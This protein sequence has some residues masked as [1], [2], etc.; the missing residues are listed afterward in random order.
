MSKFLVAHLL[1]ARL[2]CRRHLPAARP[3][4]ACGLARP[5]LARKRDQRVPAHAAAREHGVFEGACARLAAES[6]GVV[7]ESQKTLIFLRETRAM[8]KREWMPGRPPWE[9]GSGN[10]SRIRLCATRFVV[11]LPSFLPRTVFPLP[12][13]TSSHTARKISR[14]TDTPL[15]H[16]AQSQAARSQGGPRSSWAG[17]SRFVFTCLT[18]VF[19]PLWILPTSFSALAAGAFCMQDAWGVERRSPS[20]SLR[21]RCPR[22]AQRS[23][24]LG[25]TVSSASAQIEAMDAVAARLLAAVHAFANLPT[26]DLAPETHV[27]FIS[28]DIRAPLLVGAPLISCAPMRQTGTS[29]TPASWSTS[30]ART[31]AGFV[32][33]RSVC[34]RSRCYALVELATDMAESGF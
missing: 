12:A 21:W 34:R 5:A 10:G 11:L 33:R 7:S 24:Q 32:G 1:P 2:Y 18:A 29:R 6:H 9:R 15:P 27:G 13:S 20:I 25:N 4:C 3:L 8:L 31:H 28:D 19:I 22:S 14:P 23:L 16:R 30:R 17:A 26:T